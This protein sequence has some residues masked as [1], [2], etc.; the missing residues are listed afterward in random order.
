M[1]WLLENERNPG[2]PTL[3]SSPQ[4]GMIEPSATALGKLRKGQ[5]AVGAAQKFLCALRYA[6][7]SKPNPGLAWEQIARAPF[8]PSF[9]VNG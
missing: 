4:G 6:S 7:S 3:G 9:G 5:S 1:Y 2:D 8:T